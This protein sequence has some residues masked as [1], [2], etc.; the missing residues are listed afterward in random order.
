MRLLLRIK[1][2]RSLVVRAV[3]LRT[4]STIAS[5]R[6]HPPIE[7]NPSE[8]RHGNSNGL[9]FI[10]TDADLDRLD[11]RLGSSRLRVAM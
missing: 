7:P 3:P 9:R 4:P 1:R 10:M 11:A 5:S 2:G 6:P 8:S